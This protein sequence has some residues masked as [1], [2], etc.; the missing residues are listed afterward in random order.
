MKKL[1]FVITLLSLLLVSA[2]KVGLIRFDVINKSGMK[3]AIGLN[4]QEQGKFYYL[5]VAEGDREAPVEAGFTI[6]RDIY[7]TQVYYIEPDDSYFTCKQPKPVKLN[8]LHDVRLVVL[9]CIH[10]PVYTGEPFMLKYPI[11]KHVR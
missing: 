8:M 6:A 1:L 9:P 3:V 5:K 4:G 11:A 10:D 7:R 2:S